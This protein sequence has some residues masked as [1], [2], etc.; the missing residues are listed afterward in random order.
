[1]TFDEAMLTEGLRRCRMCRQF[2]ELDNIQ[3]N[4]LCFN[5]GRTDPPPEQRAG[6]ATSC[7]PDFAWPRS[8]AAWALAT[9]CAL[10]ILALFALLAGD[11]P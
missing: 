6:P 11:G 7:P 5:C 4:G 2:N 8:C 3:W 10:T 9:L 1:M